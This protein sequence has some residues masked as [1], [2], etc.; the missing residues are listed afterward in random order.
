MRTSNW[1]L[2][3]L[4]LGILWTV[5]VLFVVY[6]LSGVLPGGGVPFDDAWIHFV[7]ARNLAER[8]EVSFNPGQWSGGT[9]SLLWDLLLAL[10]YRLSGRMLA[11]AY[12]LGVVCYLLA[13]TALFLLLVTTFG[14][15]ARGC[16]SALVGA[17]GFAAIGFVPYL[18][19]SGMDT[20]L[21]LALALGSLAAF[22]RGHYRL[23]GWLLA[24]VIITRI[25]GVGV[26]VLLGLAA[27]VGIWSRPRWRSLLQVIMPPVLVLGLYLLFNWAVTG[28]LL[29]TTMAGRKWLWGLPESWWAFSLERTGN[30]LRDWWNLITHFI[31]PGSSWASPLFLGG[32]IILGLIRVLVGAAHRQPTS[33]GLVLLVAWVLA[34]N[35]A[36]LFLAPLATWRHQVPNLV[37]L[38]TLASAGLFAITRMLRS[39]RCYQWVFALGILGI[40]VCLLPG[41]IAYSQ[42]YA[43]NVAHINNVHVAAGRW[44]DAHL[45]D[46]AV[47]AAFDIG[48]ISYLG[49]RWTLDLGGLTDIRFVRE[50]L[51]PGRTVDYLYERGATHLAMPE[52][53]WPGQTDLGARLGLVE[54]E[55]TARLR[56]HSLAAFEIPPYIRPP[57]TSLPYQFYP[58]YYRIAIYEI[59]WLY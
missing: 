37:L 39:R 13:A 31:L 21:F 41:T 53:A 42:T 22:V 12:V 28:H 7:F 34:H 8:G 23:T 49:D 10:G 30:F 2:S 18:A 1:R 26:A 16:T 45:P 51:Y 57:F 33:L 36:Y 59:E 40:L 56:F 35:L 48:A 24:A 46:D 52:P 20:L 47:V 4:C 50:Y 43:E 54:G 11:T 27:L 29:P 25:E 3:A 6:Y 5:Q 55:P 32:L 15:T 44:I 58:A 38:S 17:I 19:L 9:T 14:Q